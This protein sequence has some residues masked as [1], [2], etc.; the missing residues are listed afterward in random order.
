MSK[1][2]IVHPRP[3]SESSGLKLLGIEVNC[4]ACR[5]LGVLIAQILNV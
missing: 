1:F 3:C 4:I 2:R 5:M